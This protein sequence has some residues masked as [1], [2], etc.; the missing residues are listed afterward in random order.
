[1]T[2]TNGTADQRGASRSPPCVS[3][4]EALAYLAEF[5][6]V[7]R[8]GV[9]PS[10]FGLTRIRQLLAA[11]GQPERQYPGVLIAGTNGKGSTAAMVAHAL[12]AAG[13]RTGL[14]TQPH[15]HTIRERVQIDGEP[16][17]PETFGCVMRGV[18]AR[19]EQTAG[20]ASPATAYEVMTALAFKVFE[21]QAVDLAV[22]EVGLGGRLDATNVVDAAVSA[23]TSISLDHT[24]VLGDTVEAIAA[25]KADVIKSGRPCISAPQPPVA[26]AVIRQT[27]ARRGACLRVAEE[28]GAR[29]DKPP[30]QWDL[31]TGHGRIERVRPALRGPFQR[32][33]AAVATTILDALDDSGV[34]HLDLD[35]VR[36]GIEEVVWPG[37]FEVIPGEPVVVV[38]GA[39][40]VEAAQRLREA[41]DP[42]YPQAWLV[43]VLGIAA[44]KD[45]AGFVRALCAGPAVSQR[46]SSAEASAPSARVR[47]VVAT[48][49]CHPRALDAET[50]AALARAAGFP[51][52]TAPTVA[53]AIALAREGASPGDVVVATGSLYVIAEAREALGLA[54]PSAEASFDPWAT[55]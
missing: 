48:R 2:D 15:L 5:V 6:D 20:T 25:E 34:V 45:V 1:M 7:E 19:V 40:N 39:H 24:Q 37:R 33:N 32:T 51:A 38:D 27:A 18:R 13:Y 14:Y 9:P 49:A 29:W 53:T 8:G 21:E 26:M 46:R 3:Y 16:I 10:I 22:V 30:R 28:D 54:Q 55:R 43:L 23:I 47:L 36:A 12:R 17:S 44:D 35:A 11:L 52:V 42:A 31:L 50:I 4:S 41:L